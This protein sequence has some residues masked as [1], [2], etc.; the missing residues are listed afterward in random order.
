MQT[1]EFKDGH[2]ESINLAM[3]WKTL[4]TNPRIKS[5]LYFMAASSRKNAAFGFMIVVVHQITLMGKYH[6]FKKAP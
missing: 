6:V 3:Q 4:H 2:E 1:K 5:G